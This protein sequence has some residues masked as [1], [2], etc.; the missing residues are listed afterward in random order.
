M[1]PMWFALACAPKATPLPCGPP[2]VGSALCGNDDKSG[3]GLVGGRDVPVPTVVVRANGGLPDEIV[4]RV[5]Q[6]TRT[7]LAACVPEQ[8][9]VTLSGTIA[10]DATFDVVARSDLPDG[11]AACMADHARATWL[12]PRPIDGVPVQFV[13][14]V[15]VPAP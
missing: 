13:A 10:A 1:T 7:T 6:A 12:F 3:G 5:I 4:A 15:E 9:T 2:G 8:G 11:V 14:I